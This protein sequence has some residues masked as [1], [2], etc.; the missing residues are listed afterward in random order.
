MNP[1]RLIGL[2]ATLILAAAPALAA[3]VSDQSGPASD[4]KS[5]AVTTSDVVLIQTTLHGT[6]VVQFTNFSI[7]TASY[8][9][10]YRPSPSQ[11]VMSGTGQ[12]VESYDRQL[13]P[14]GSYRVSP[15]T[16]HDTI[17]KAGDI[18]FEWSVGDKSYG[19]LYYNPDR[20][21]VTVLP[22]AAFDGDI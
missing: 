22:A 17:V 20:A 8:R 6:A 18:N 19:W 5:L 14:D 1:F 15:R 2:V 10:R 21:R 4:R 13:M 9:W 7:T 12:V 11:N 16:D 3:N